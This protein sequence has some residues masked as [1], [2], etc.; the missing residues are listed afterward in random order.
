MRQLMPL[1][2]SPFLSLRACPLPVSVA[3][4]LRTIRARVTSPS[5][6]WR[7]RRTAPVRATP[8]RTTHARTAS[9]SSYRTPHRRT[10]R[11]REGGARR[12]PSAATRSNE[13]LGS[14]RLMLLLLSSLQ[15]SADTPTGR[16]T[17]CPAGRARTRLQH[18][19][20]STLLFFRLTVCHP[21]P[22]LLSF[23]GLSAPAAAIAARAIDGGGRDFFK[24]CSSVKHTIAPAI[25]T[26]KL[27]CR[28][29]RR[30][31]FPCARTGR[32]ARAR[33][34]VDDKRVHMS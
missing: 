23:D 31:I 34:R 27:H 17:R 1:L 12:H 13:W 19:K 4:R 7:T 2:M 9:C 16:V 25:R 14:C 21:R 29:R 22:A 26:K 5:A 3:T 30:K 10:K 33:A 18:R 6:R 20:P 15:I 8:R 11:A 28:A 32:R 24:F